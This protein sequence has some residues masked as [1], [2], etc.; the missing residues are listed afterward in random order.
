MPGR[1]YSLW[2]GHTVLSDNLNNCLPTTSFLCWYVFLSLSPHVCVI[3]HQPALPA[4]IQ[5]VSDQRPSR[6][7]FAVG[8]VA[9][10]Q[11]SLILPNNH[12]SIVI[13]VCVIIP[14][15]VSWVPPWT[16]VMCAENCFV[17][18]EWKV[19]LPQCCKISN[20]NCNFATQY[21]TQTNW[22]HSC[23]SSTEWYE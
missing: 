19:Q 6:P 4:C 18:V 11:V 14:S 23:M 21:Y 1:L 3:L 7:R 16:F 5:F 20:D 12:R 17:L 9:G 13:H 2:G 22:Q 8:S 10:W 15:A